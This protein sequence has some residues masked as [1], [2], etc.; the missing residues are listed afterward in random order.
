MKTAAVIPAAGAGAR[1]NK[2]LAK[3]YLPLGGK[4]ILARTLESLA[5]VAIIDEI[6][7]ALH[8]GEFDY[9]RREIAKPHSLKKISRLTEGGPTRQASVRNALK[10]IGKDIDIVL[11][12]DAVRPFI[13]AETVMEIIAQA[14]A[15]G[16]AAAAVPATDTIKRTDRGGFI[17]GTVPREG[18]WTVQ[19]PQAFRRELIA[20]AH[21][22]AE[23]DRFQGTDDAS[24]VER[25]GHKVK[26]VEGSRWNLKITA[27]EDLVVAEGLLRELNMP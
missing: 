20:E 2:S 16:A 9:F 5:D 23:K 27:A 1:M 17:N 18:L 15:E 25:L 22:R 4:P 11:V 10:E 3:Q 8:P 26:I 12:H 21:A 19:T 6:L 13:E 24:L 14:A 7:V